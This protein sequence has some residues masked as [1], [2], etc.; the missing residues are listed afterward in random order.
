M[1]VIEQVCEK[2]QHGCIWEFISMIFDASNTK[3]ECIHY[4]KCW[5]AFIEQPIK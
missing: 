3:N 2:Q 1:N 5:E 4:Q